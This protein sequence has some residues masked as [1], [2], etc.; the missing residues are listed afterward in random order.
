MLILP[1]QDMGREDHCVNRVIIW[2][3]IGGK[4]AIKNSERLGVRVTPKYGR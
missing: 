3:K 1:I 2:R 4:L